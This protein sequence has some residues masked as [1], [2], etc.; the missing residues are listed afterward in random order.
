MMNEK[1]NNFPFYDWVPRPIGI[2]VLILMFIPP[3]FSGGAYLSNVSEMTGSLG[4]WTEDIQLAAF[5]T[6][7]GMCL[8]PPF[9][10]S[11][12]QARRTKQTY[13]WC[14]S[15]LVLL[16]L[17]CAITRSLPWLLLWCMLTGI[18][19]SVAMINC[20]FTIAPYLTGINTLNMFTATEE[21]TPEVQYKQERMRTF[22]MPVLY[23]VILIIAQMS[24]VVVA[25]FAEHYTWQ[26]SYWVVAG[27]LLI[28][29][30]LI[31]ILMKD[32]HRP[33]HYQVNKGML[34]DMLL[35]MLTLGSM[36]YFL[37]FGK[38]LDW[39]SSGRI[40]VCVGLFLMGV[41]CLLVRGI[42]G[43][44]LPLSIF[45]YRNILISSI[46]FVAFMIFNSP[47]NF[48]GTF[49]KLSTQANNLHVAELSLYAIIGCLVGFVLSMWMVVRR[50]H[51]RWIFAVGLL[52][53]GVSN[54]FMYFQ[55]T[56]EG[57]L[58]YLQWAMMINFTGLMILYALV[59]AFG[60]KHLKARY[61]VTFVFL[62]ICLRNAVGPVIGSCIYGNWMQHK[63]QYYLTC[64]VQNV[65]RQHPAIG[66]QPTTTL[67]ARIVR[68]SAISA[69]KDISGTTVWLIL[70]TTLVVLIL[71]YHKGETS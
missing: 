60:M 31:G 71:P 47:S 49:A 24:N 54:A 35:M 40:I 12:L 70:G 68:Q 25:W 8:F 29:I 51:F 34:V 23:G 69:M 55:Y 26:E 58:P 11:F 39:F 4:V 43:K 41:G 62:M 6:N 1:K 28:A 21:P 48:I 13:L 50:W 14:F 38:T 61:L 18:V 20:T 15:L 64:L 65:D 37:V 57:Y 17:L 19:R 53:M 7:I 42:K 5:F 66:T 56:T 27:M 36:T 46:L 67:Y 32:E 63:Q 3:T 10:V 16:N 2:I 59:A 9:M 30:L 52:L 33:F 22:L 44:Y 45:R